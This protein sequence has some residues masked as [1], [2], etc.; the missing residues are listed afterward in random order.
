MIAMCDKETTSTDSETGDEVNKVTD[1]VETCREDG[2]TSLYH[3]GAEDL[4]PQE[5]LEVLISLGCK[6]GTAAEVAK[7]L[8]EAFDGH[9]LDILTASIEQLTQVKGIGFVK[10]CQIKAAFE[11]M[12][13]I[14]S[15]FKEEHPVIASTDD[16]VHLLAPHMRFLKQEEFRVILLDSKKR[17]IRHCQVSLGSLDATIVH[18]REIFRPAV[19]AGAKYIVLVHNHPSGD[20]E[21][22]KQDI[23]LTQKLFMSGKILDIEVLDHII[24][25]FPDYL[26]MKDKGLM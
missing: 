26:S 2:R 4:K 17:L 1:P 6:E 20:P 11:L 8:W 18:P 23:L 5:L 25:G 9:L 10:V 7:N 21:P 19:A 24:I 13:R 22:S 12:N 3:Y 14:E 15:Y 16:V